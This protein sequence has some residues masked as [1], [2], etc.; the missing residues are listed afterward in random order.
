MKFKIF[1]GVFLLGLFASSCFED[2]SAKDVTLFNPLMINDF[3]SSTEI[4]VTQGDRLRV[5]VL[6]Y[7][8]GTDDAKLEYEWRLEGHGQHLDLGHSMILD[9]VINVPMNRDAYSLLFKVTDTEYG[10]TL[11]KKY[12]LYVTGQYVAG[13]LVADTKD[14]MTSDIHLVSSKN[15]TQD[16]NREE[17]KHVFWNV[18][19]LNNGQNVNG[20]IQDMKNVVGRGFLE[21]SIATDH[22]I[23]DL[24]PLDNFTVMRRNNDMFI[25]PFEGEMNVGKLG[26]S[27]SGPY[28]IAVVNGFLH[29]RTQ[30]EEV[31][32][33]GVGLVLSDLSDD[34][35]ITEYKYRSTRPRG[36]EIYGV[37]FDKKNQ[38]F[39][40]FP[41]IYGADKNNLRI[42]KRKSADGK[43]DPNK[44]GNVDCK[45]IGYG[46]NNT[47]YAVIQNLDSKVYE[48]WEFNLDSD[49]E[50]ADNVVN[51]R[52]IL[53]QCPEIDKAISFSSQAMESILYYA[54]GDKVYTAL[55]TSEHPKA[56]PKFSASYT[57]D[58]ITVSNE[59]IT[60][61]R[62]V[63]ECPGKVE[64]PGEG[65]E[66]ETLASGRNMITVVTYNDVTKEGKVTVVPIRSLSTGEV[67]E[68]PK[69]YRVY[70]GFGRIL[71]T[72]CFHTR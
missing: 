49:D 9:T 50:S 64:I 24:D 19:S 32:T 25:K 14:G 51:R 41:S 7:K 60:E 72:T 42:F 3:L 2:E 8:E 11:S 54:T 48:V 58:G 10:L 39:L 5:K 18:Y 38:R 43:L 29:K 52:Y 6:A 16:Y 45:Y 35:Y 70:D 63:D 22:L 27:S 56:Y 33:Y 37:A 44:P 15:F 1:L 13:L 21:L 47:L 59:K 26:T 28:D 34:Y 46:P 20:L 53:D 67:V 23:E 17:D 62:V 66:T 68:D 31:I 30:Y 12:N 69:F 61:I 71:K 65:G 4:Y 55:M 40:A 36:Y 57:H